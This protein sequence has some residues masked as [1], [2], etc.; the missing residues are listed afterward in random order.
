MSVE[1]L[2][3]LSLRCAPEET[4]YAEV[5]NCVHENSS[6]DSLQGYVGFF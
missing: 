3:I 1:E 5:D 4:P 2:E 6:L